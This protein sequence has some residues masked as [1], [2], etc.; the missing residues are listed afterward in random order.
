SHDVDGTVSVESVGYAGADGV[1][2]HNEDGSVTFSPNANFNGDITLDV[3]VVDDDGATASTTAGIETLAV[4]DTPV[5]EGNLAYN[6][7]ED[8][9]ITFSQEQLLA[10]ASDV[11][12]DSLSAANLTVEGNATVTANDDGSF[13]VTPEAD[14][15]GDIALSFDVSDGIE[16]VASGVDLAVNPVNDAPVIQ[17]QSDDTTDAVVDLPEPLIDFESM[18]VDTDVGEGQEFFDGAEQINSGV[19]SDQ[20]GETSYTLTAWVQPD[21]DSAG[22]EMI[23]CGDDMGYDFSLLANNGHAAVYTG[24]GV[25]SLSDKLPT[26][27][28]T[29]L[30]AVFNT[31]TDEVSLFVNGEVALTSPI[32]YEGSGGNWTLGGH[33]STEHY[34]WDDAEDFNGI[35]AEAKVYDEVLTETQIS[36]LY[37]MGSQPAEVDDVNAVS[38]KVLLEPSINEDGLFSLTDA[39]ILEHVTDIDSD[40]V[41]VSEVS[42]SGDNGELIIND[43]GTYHFQP[44]ADWHGEVELNITVTDDGGLSDSGHVRF[45]VEPVN[46]IAPVPAREFEFDEDGTLVVSQADLIGSMTDVEGDHLTASELATNNPHVTV[47][48]NEDGSFT[49]N[50]SADYNHA[51]GIPMTFSVSD[52]TDVVDGHAALTIHPVNDVP[53]APVL[54]MNGE[55]DQVLVIDPAFII[56][57]VTD[58]DGDDISLERITVKHPENATI[59]QQADGMFHMLTPP[60]FFGAVALGYEVSDGTDTVEGSINVDVIPV[61]DK[62]FTEGNAHLTTKEDD[63]FT[64]NEADLLNLFGDIDTDNLVVSRIITTEGEDAGELA[65]DGNGNWTFTPAPNFAGTSDIQVIV[66][67][68]EFET[69]LDVPIY[70]RPIAD[71]VVITTDHEG[72]LVF[73]EDEVGH[74]GLNMLM[75][76]ESETLS[77]LV[78][79]GFPVGFEVSDGEHTIVITYPGQVLNVT[80]WNVDDLALNPPQDYSGNF[81]LTVSA[82]TVDYGDEP[83]E[84]ESAETSVPSGDFETGQDEPLLL[85]TAELL[86]MADSVDANN[87][88]DVH[89][90]SF[91]K[92]N[93]GLIEDN[94]DGTWSVTPAEGFTGELDI[95]YVVEQD[96]MLHDA[97]SSIAVRG[98]EGSNP[99]PTV[100]AIVTTDVE[101]GNKLFFT[102]EDMLAQLSDNDELHIESAFLSWGEGLLEE[103]DEGGYTFTPAEGFTGEAHIAFV[104]SDGD[105]SLESHFKVNVQSTSEEQSLVISDDGSIIVPMTQIAQELG[106]E[107]ADVVHEMHYLGEQGTLIDNGDSETH[108]FWPGPDFNG[109]LAIETV[110]QNGEV[111]VVEFAVPLE[112]QTETVT[113]SSSVT[114]DE[115]SVETPDGDVAPDV[116]AESVDEVQSDDQLEPDFTAAPGSDIRVNVP[117]EVMENYEN[118]DHVLISNL[119]SDVS[120]TDGLEQADGS[121]MMAGDLSQS[122]GVHLGEDFSGEVGLH[123]QA[124]DEYDRPLADASSDI[125]IEVS[126]EYA[127]DPSQTDNV[128]GIDIPAEEAQGWTQADDSDSGIDAMDDSTGLEQDPMESGSSQNDI[129][130]NLI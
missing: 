100:D 17:R 102:D 69:T 64:F 79:T 101:E 11:D 119:P 31:E 10:N 61:N 124:Y 105:N 122:I 114:T 35:I 60:D 111:S 36:T 23:I 88:G 37:D 8:G 9:S 42:Y 125:S 106:L 41:T 121:I 117:D 109:E 34:H 4:N 116:P 81:F 56:G 15:N 55:E 113:H 123:F 90:V 22:R 20:T 2:V 62:P 1:L 33:A 53:D 32:T 45:T 58:I 57:Q 99:T 85:T 130:D 71:G 14:F 103:H 98:E 13:T 112:S 54:T 51:D 91:A 6:V 76:D 115:M 65:D 46:D 50:A 108:T 49:L 96:G 16:V 12:G 29:Q 48:A 5:V 68:G 63:A 80:H 75:I 26:D 21:E 83:S 73:N 120:I 44:H 84:P 38:D 78:I 118:V 67:D 107:S 52:G 97:Q 129:D 70:V 72:P 43:D 3:V 126:E 25:V 59:Q 128:N 66:S 18:G 39:D 89:M 30:T 82:T 28:M 95:V 19:A 77:N 74:L 92:S 86:E 40:V 110:L 24:S 93:Q 7:D 104:A 94:H 47:T 87:E 27:E 127:L